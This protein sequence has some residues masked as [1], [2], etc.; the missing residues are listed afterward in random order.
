MRLATIGAAMVLGMGGVLV[1]QASAVPLG[2]TQGTPDITSGFIT[3]TYDGTNLTASGFSAS[4]DYD[5]I[6]PPDHALEGTFDIS[7]LVD[8]LG[9]ASSGSLIITGKIDGAGNT[10][11]QL[12]TGNLTGFGFGPA[13]TPFEFLFT[14]TGGSLAGDFGSTVGVILTAGASSNYD[15]DFDGGFSN[16][17]L[18]GVSDTFAVRTPG[19]PEPLTASLGGLAM[20]ALALGSLRRRSR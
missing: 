19:V 11:D 9:N 18:D 4:L 2:L 20:G 16:T 1:Q 5:G 6:A 7:A 13:G 8:G 15:G 12:L 14:V 3:T 17:G 10:T